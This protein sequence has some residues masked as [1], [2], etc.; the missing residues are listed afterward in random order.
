[1][2]SLFRILLYTSTCWGVLPLFGLK[3]VVPFFLTT[4]DVLPIVI[5]VG[6]TVFRPKAISLGKLSLF[7]KTCISGLG[8]LLL[9]NLYTVVSK[10]GEAFAAIQYITAL[11]RPVSIAVLLISVLN[12]SKHSTEVRYITYRL[13]LR[14]V[15]MI[16]TLQFLAAGLQ[17]VAPTVGAL[18]IPSIGEFQSGFAALD[19]G[20]VSGLLP[21][22]IDFAYLA[23]AAYVVLV[24]DLVRRRNRAPNFL[25]TAIFAYFIN[26]SGSDA[27][28]VCF[29]GFALWIYS[30]SIGLQVKKFLSA[31]TVFMTL[32]LLVVNGAVLEQM[33][34]DK[35][36]NM[37]LSRLGLLFISA[38]QLISEQP[39]FLL[40][41]LGPDFQMIAGV[42]SG[43][44]ETLA[45][46]AEEAG[47]TIVNDVFWF[48][49]VVSLGIPLA[50]SYTAGMLQLISKLCTP[51]AFNGSFPRLFRVIVA[52]IIFAGLFNQILLVRSFYTVLLVGMFGHT[53]IG[54]RQFF[55]P[56]TSKISND[57]A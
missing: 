38:P 17:V 42:L 6:I 18:L 32:M 57:K 36:D 25:F 45:V 8:L 31:I 15:K 14:D 2:L 7:Q 11:L 16:I 40:T 37:M 1:M 28:T 50:F 20:D 34:I 10:G 26:R 48:A 23:V 24:L 39:S 56:M 9:A 4:F 43:L 52:I 54:A 3:E 49:T 19:E 22:S 30:S 55:A 27:A 21:N 5:A 47:S 44:P 53:F 33:L 51:E 12:R 35:I 29:I 13:L 46:L 41:G